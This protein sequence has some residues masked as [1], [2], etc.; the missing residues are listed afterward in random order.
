MPGLARSMTSYGNFKLLGVHALERGR[1]GGAI[2]FSADGSRILASDTSHEVRIWDASSGEL[3]FSYP[4]DESTSVSP[5]LSQDG[6]TVAAPDARGYLRAR[7][8]RDGA[9]RTKR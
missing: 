4:F 9:S 5:C 2:E 3:K 6:H 1:E 8:T 7:D